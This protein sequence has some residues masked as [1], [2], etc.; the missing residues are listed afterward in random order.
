MD[1]LKVSITI[2]LDQVNQVLAALAKRPF[3]EVV[4]LIGTIRNQAQDQIN[5]AANI[6][7]QIVEHNETPT[8]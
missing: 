6:P 4:E 2:D 5:A 8:T 7:D 3:D 1:K